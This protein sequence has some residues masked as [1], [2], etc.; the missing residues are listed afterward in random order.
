MTQ[1][2]LGPFAVQP[3]GELRL[4]PAGPP[5][6]A[7]RF[8]WRGRPCEAEVEEESLRIAAI[9]G[10]V[11][12]TA[13]PGVDRRGALAALAGLPGH[14]PEGWRLRLLP[15]HRV[16][17]ETEAPLEAAPTAVRLITEMVRFALA[18]DPYLDRLEAAG[19]AAPPSGG[20]RLAR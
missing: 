17:L 18:L 2:H 7:L 6:A 19:T 5:R 13:D 9:A 16:R 8:A 3:T 12:S 4:R 1:L 14:L 10:Q 11:P 15:D 20:D